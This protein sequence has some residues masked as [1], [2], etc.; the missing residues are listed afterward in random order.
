MEVLIGAGVVVVVLITV[1]VRRDRRPR[2]EN[3]DGQLVERDASLRLQRHR[4][5][6]RAAEGAEIQ[7]LLERRR[8]RDHR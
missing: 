2:T 7:A 8:G 4:G 6:A 3:L 5:E 1:L